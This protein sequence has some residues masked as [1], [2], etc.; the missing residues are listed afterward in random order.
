MKNKQWLVKKEFDS[1]HFQGY[2]LVHHHKGSS[3]NGESLSFEI[4]ENDVYEGKKL[5]FCVES[6]STGMIE[7]QIIFVFS[8]PPDRKG[9]QFVGY[10]S[11][12]DGTIWSYEQKKK[13]IVSADVTN[14]T[15]LKS[16][17]PVKRRKTFIKWFQQLK[18]GIVHYHPF[19]F[20]RHAA[21]LSFRFRLSEGESGKG[22]ILLYEQ[23]Y[24]ENQQPKQDHLQ[25]QT[26]ISKKKMIL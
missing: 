1:T 14:G 22:T 8:T 3:A 10:L 20:G 11:P 9:L 26:S 12:I 7:I 15:V 16:V 18:N 13:C 6:K 19:V 17:Y 4:V 21:I 2:C 25:K 24:E 23:E 5:V